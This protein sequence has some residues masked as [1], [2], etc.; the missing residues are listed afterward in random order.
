VGYL[1]RKHSGNGHYMDGD[2]INKNS[3]KFR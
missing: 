3:L 2:Q 1:S